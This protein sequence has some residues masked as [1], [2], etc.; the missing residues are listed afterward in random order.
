MEHPSERQQNHN[1]LQLHIG[2]LTARARL[3][4]CG[5]I[6]IICSPGEMWIPDP[7]MHTCK[8]ITY[9]SSCMIF[10]INC[11]ERHHVISRLL[12]SRFNVISRLLSSPFN[13]CACSTITELWTRVGQHKNMV[14]KKTWRTEKYGKVTDKW[15]KELEDWK[16]RESY[17]QKY[18][19]TAPVKTMAFQDDETWKS[20][21]RRDYNRIYL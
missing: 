7:N 16:V 20:P 10:R 2:R 18:L 4:K 9:D 5:H 11:K 19:R 1:Y 12:T 21:T 17:W 14:D 13:S 3:Q 8:S 6:S 15:Q